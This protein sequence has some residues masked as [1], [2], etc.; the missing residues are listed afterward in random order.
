MRGRPA[1]TIKRDSR[2]QR[3]YVRLHPREKQELE[4]RAAARKMSVSEYILVMTLSGTG[5]VTNEP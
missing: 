3:V 2:T 5:G 4:R 1:G